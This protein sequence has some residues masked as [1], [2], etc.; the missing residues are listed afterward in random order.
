MTTSS[1]LTWNTSSEE[2]AFDPEDWLSYRER[3]SGRDRPKL[4]P[5]AVQ[6]L[7]GS[8]WDAAV[9]RADDAPDDFTAAGHPFV[10]LNGGRIAVGRSAKGSDAAGG[11]DELLALGVQACV[12]IG[13]AGALVPELAVG[14]LAVPSEALADDGVACHYVGPLRYV[15]A[16]ATLAACLRETVAASGA[17]AHRGRVWTTSAHF[18]QT[19]PRLQVFSDEGC[20]AVD[21]ESAGVFAVGRHRGR[22]VARLVVVGDTIADR[23]FHVPEHAE[24]PSADAILDLAVGA[25]E[26]WQAAA[27]RPA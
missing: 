18:R 2:S 20:V 13:G 7:I 10:L 3:T 17:A 12:S 27:G 14:T 25:L 4:P 1:P 6:T 23:R 15:E 8:V 5:L 16:D 11:L 9:A 19:V 26:R 24:V 21:N 22:A